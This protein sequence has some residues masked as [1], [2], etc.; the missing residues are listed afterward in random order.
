MSKLSTVKKIREFNRFYLP[1]LSLLDRKYLGSEYSVTDARI[2]FEICAM[3][4]CNA[5]SLVQ[6]L[7]IDKSY[8]SRIIKR[9]EKNGLIRR[10]TSADDLRVNV[11]YLTEYGENVTQKLIK[12]SDEQISQLI[13]NLTNEDCEAIEN[14][15]KTIEIIFNR[16]EDQYE[17]C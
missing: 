1:I 15:M 6:S 12:E 3:D 11:I 2:L 16:K 4:N 10:V 5:N 7:H 8:L 13:N 9:F 14:A 17:N